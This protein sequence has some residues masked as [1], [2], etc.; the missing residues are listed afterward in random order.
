M[1]ASKSRFG[2]NWGVIFW[3]AVVVVVV[4]LTLTRDLLVLLLANHLD[5]WKAQAEVE[6]SDPRSDAARGVDDVHHHKASELSGLAPLLLD[7]NIQEYDFR[8]DEVFH[9]NEENDFISFQYDNQQGTYAHANEGAGEYENDVTAVFVAL[10]ARFHGLGGQDYIWESIRQWRIFH[11]VSRL[12]TI[13]QSCKGSQFR[14]DPSAQNSCGADCNRVRYRYPGVSNRLA[15]EATNG[16]TRYHHSDSKINVSDSVEKCYPSDGGC[17]ARTSFPTYFREKLFSLCQKVSHDHRK[18]PLFYHQNVTSHLFSLGTSWQPSFCNPDVA[19]LPMTKLSTLSEHQPSEDYQCT[20]RLVNPSCMVEHRFDQI[21]SRPMILRHRTSGEADAHDT[22]LRQLPARNSRADKHRLEECRELDDAQ[23]QGEKRRRIRNKIFLVLD[24]DTFLNDPLVRHNAALYNVT[25]V[26]KEDLFKIQQLKLE[27]I[28]Q[29]QKTLARKNTN[30]GNATDSQQW[31]AFLDLFFSGAWERYDRVFY[32]QGFMHPGG[33]R[34]TGNQNFNKFVVERF[35]ALQALMSYFHLENVIHLENDVLVYANFGKIIRKLSPGCVSQNTT[36]QPRDDS[37]NRSGGSDNGTLSSAIRSYCRHALVSVSPGRGR[38]FG[39]VPGTLYIRDAFALLHLNS[40]IND[41]LSCGP[42]FGKMVTPKYAND[43]TYL[44]NYYQYYGS[45]K[46]G[47]FPSWEHDKYENCLWEPGDDLLA[48]PSVSRSYYDSLLL[49]Q[50]DFPMMKN[51]TREDF[52]PH[53]KDSFSDRY[54]EDRL[55]AFSLAASLELVQFILQQS[56]VS[57]TGFTCPDLL[58][59]N[60][61]R[62]GNHDQAIQ[63]WFHNC[64]ESFLH[65]TEDKS[66]RASPIE[67]AIRDCQYNGQPGRTLPP[68]GVNH[69]Q[70]N[71]VDDAG[72][73]QRQSRMIFRD[74]F[75]PSGFGQWNSGAIRAAVE[76][77]LRQ[78]G[79]SESDIANFK[80]VN[81]F[82]DLKYNHQPGGHFFTVNF[83]AVLSQLSSA[84]GISSQHTMPYYGEVGDNN[85][86]TPRTADRLH[87]VLSSQRWWWDTLLAHPQWIQFTA[88]CAAP[89]VSKGRHPP[90]HVRESVHHQERFFRQTPNLQWVLDHRG[91]RIPIMV[92]KTKYSASDVK[93]P[94]THESDNG[95]ALLTLHIHA[96]NLKAFRSL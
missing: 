52:F 63:E 18:G 25:A 20:E 74:L 94:S 90:K 21:P 22:S 60:D 2:K 29:E 76:D 1:S 32:I 89:V 55:V 66:L 11:P 64:V 24:R 33:T 40:F 6:V 38:K 10:G 4:Q 81:I 56:D 37:T 80:E 69:E 93:E 59:L 15:D 77:R 70:S 78:H 5:S 26:A 35:F 68:E 42:K 12:T 47:L 58:P 84:V 57:T 16:G 44:W 34:K 92:M 96:K 86:Q 48:L 7:F 83:S 8:T 49:T 85:N 73:S 50:V 14:V 87:N 53:Y 61:S 31:K 65:R 41:L 30:E 82:Q 51:D 45:Q 91:R 46:F 88:R 71:K 54:T 19:S 27:K 17:N 23:Q 39:I 79:A 67:A 43:M 62:D 13:H 9:D 36:N 28:L 72:K 3:C 75:D 95:Y